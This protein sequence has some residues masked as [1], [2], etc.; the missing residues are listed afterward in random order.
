MLE[1]GISGAFLEERVSSSRVRVYMCVCVCVC[2]YRARAHGTYGIS[3]W[4]NI[5]YVTDV[6][7]YGIV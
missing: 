4:Q 3:E 6:N 5:D 7:T 1:L 2:G